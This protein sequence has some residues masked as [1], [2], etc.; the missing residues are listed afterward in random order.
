MINYFYPELGDSKDGKQN[1]KFVNE[2]L[3]PSI[4]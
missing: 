3:N 2:L 4:F 1:K